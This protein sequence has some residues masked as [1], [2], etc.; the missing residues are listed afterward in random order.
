M[1]TSLTRWTPTG[2]LFR[3]RFSRLF[4]QAFNDMLSNYEGS[5]E[6][7]R[8]NWLPPVD[9][10]ET[11]DAL[12]LTAELPGLS[13]DDV[14]ITVENHTLTLRGER[15][16]EKDVQKDSYHRIERAYGTFSRTFSLPTNV[17]TD[18]VDASFKDGVLN[19]EIPKAEEA[20]PRRISIK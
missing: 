11:E 6:T 20:K 17:R 2:D 18:K 4:D 14:E 1:T 16:L 10:R 3:T 13:K 5:E 19:L 7:A 8:A 12:H 15:K 9:I